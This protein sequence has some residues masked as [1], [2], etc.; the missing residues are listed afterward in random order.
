MDLRQTGIDGRVGTDGPVDVGEPEEPTNGVH[1]RAHGR[2][3]QPSLTELVEIELDVAPLDIDQ[4][5]QPVAL[6]PGDQ[7]RSW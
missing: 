7:R 5:I 1:H 4:R 3:H 2:G 6:T